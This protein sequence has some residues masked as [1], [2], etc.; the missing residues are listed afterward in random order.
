MTH[1]EQ[2]LEKLEKNIK[3][4]DAEEQKLLHSICNEIFEEYDRGSAKAVSLLLQG[5]ITALK[6]KFDNAHTR[7]LKKMGL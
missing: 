1:K 3:D 2:I 7:F 4:R 5:K 6:N